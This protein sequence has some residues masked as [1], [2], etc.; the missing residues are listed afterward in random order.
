MGT[1]T[2]LENAHVILS[3]I[4]DHIRYFWYFFTDHEIILSRLES[5]E[6]YSTSATRRYIQHRERG[7]DLKI[8]TLLLRATVI[9]SAFLIQAPRSV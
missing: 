4:L 7:V 2:V 8:L 9:C 3:Q 1:K 5:E 6:N